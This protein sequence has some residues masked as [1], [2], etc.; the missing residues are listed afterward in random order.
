M[1]LPSRMKMARFQ[2]FWIQMRKNKP[3]DESRKTG[4]T[5]GTKLAFYSNKNNNS[6]LVPVGSGLLPNFLYFF[7][8]IHESHKSLRLP[9]YIVPLI[10]TVMI[11]I[12][13]T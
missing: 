3:L 10:P 4:L 6:S 12:L 1:E 9:P 5:S 11:K 2:T 8:I 13:K 7:F